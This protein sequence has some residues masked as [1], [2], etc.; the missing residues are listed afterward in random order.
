[1][2]NSIAS[3]RFVRLLRGGRPPCPVANTC[4]IVI[5]R[6]SALKEVSGIAA[7]AQRGE[8]RV[9]AQPACLLRP[10]SASG[11]AMLPSPT[12]VTLIDHHPR[13]TV[14]YSACSIPLTSPENSVQPSAMAMS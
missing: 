6:I 2:S 4:T 11:L 1:M 3:R 5:V 10:R 13:A 12:L 7:H 8:D 9:V 14:S